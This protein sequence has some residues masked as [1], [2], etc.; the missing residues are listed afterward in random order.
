MTFSD[1]QTSLGKT[2]WDA[3]LSR[4]EAGVGYSLTRWLLIKAT[5]QHNTRDTARVPALTLPALQAVL[6]F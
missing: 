2:T 1:I 3:P 4:V 6:W 5:I